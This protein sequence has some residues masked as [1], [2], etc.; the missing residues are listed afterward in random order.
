MKVSIGMNL[1]SGAWGGGNMFG[2]ALTQWLTKQGVEVSHDLK[3]DDLDIILLAEPQVRLKI[4]AYGPQAILRYLHRKNPKALVVHRINNSSEARNDPQKKFNRLRIQANRVADHTV[5]ISRWVKEG[6]QQSGYDRPETESTV[7]LNGGDESLWQKKAPAPPPTPLSLV[8]HHWSNDPKKGFDI[9]R[10]LDEMLV[11]PTWRDRISFTYIGRLP[12]GFQFQSARTIPPLSGEE[13]AQ[14]LCRH[15]IY[16]TAAR[17][18]AAGMHH[19]EGALSGLPLLYIVSGAMPEY[20]H[21]FGL[22]FQPETFTQALEQMVA[23]YPHWAAQ[24]D[25]YP[26][27]H[28]RM[29]QNYLTLFNTLIAQRQEILARRQWWRRP[30]WFVKTRWGKES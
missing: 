3:S 23:E 21:G 29:C 22:P 20:C 16:L 6:Y 25:H 28:D 10:Q 7:I 26:F 19:I 13:L 8:T 17:N 4:S 24:M 30:V 2:K 11:H 12:E 18:E 14:E 27:T 1:Q 15:D 9:Y 5:F